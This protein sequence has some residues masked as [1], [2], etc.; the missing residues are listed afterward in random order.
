[1]VGTG[2]SPRLRR[3]RPRAFACLSEKARV[4][5]LFFW[6][7]LAR[8][9]HVTGTA[10]KVPVAKSMR[11]FASR[12]RGSQPGAWVSQQSS[13]ISSRQLLL[14]KFEELKAKFRRGKVPLPGFRGG[15]RIQ[16]DTFE[17]WQGRENRLHDR[18][19]YTH[20]SAEWTIQRLAP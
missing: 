12:R 4:S 14:T 19:L 13:I 17:F 3:G 7:E 8:Q 6:K 16:P 18:F 5:L 11:Y 2:F 20:H 15:S 9:V 1:M 10:D